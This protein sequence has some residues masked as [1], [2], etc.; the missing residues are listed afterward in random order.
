ML[1]FKL[2]NQAVKDLNN[3]WEYTFE[4]W[5]EKQADKYYNV[6]IEFC[7]KITEKQTIGKDYSFIQ[8]GLYGL[9][10]NKHIIFY[11]E[12]N[13]GFI[14]IIRFLHVMMD[15]EERIKK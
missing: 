12:S 14:E 8:K 5:S 2:T 6:L 11:R 7:G 10:V 4:T 15:V 3:I 13:L 9:R 1:N